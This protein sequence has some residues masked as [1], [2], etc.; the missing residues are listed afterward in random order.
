MAT[1]RCNQFLPFGSRTSPAIFDLFPSALE[2]MLQTQRHWKHTLHYLE[3]FLAIFLRSTVSD[4][5]SRYNEDF[6]QIRNALGFRVKEEQNAEGHSSRFLGI[7]IDTE[8]MEARLLPDTHEKAK[9]LLNPTLSLHS[10][11]RRILET[12]LGFLSFASTVVS[13]SRAFIGRLYNALTATW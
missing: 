13:A 5:P 2:W 3:D 12:I 6:S 11:K 7:E 9:A 1:C 4:A 8:E 10:V